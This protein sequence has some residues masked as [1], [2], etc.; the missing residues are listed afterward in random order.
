MPNWT[1]NY[2][3]VRGSKETLDQ[4]LND[5]VKVEG[6]PEGDYS[7][8]SWF[9]R[10]ETYDKY[11]TTNYTPDKLRPRL[12][13]PL[14]PWKKDSP[15]ITEELIAEYAQAMV[16]QRKR[17][18]AV[19][20]YDWNVK[21]YGCKWDENFFIQRVDD[22]T[23]KFNVTT[24]WVAPSVFFERISDRY[25]GLELEVDS[26]YEE[27]ENEWYTYSAGN[28]CQNDLDEFVSKLDEYI[29]NRIE[30]ADEIDGEP[31]T[32]EFK[33]KCQKAR[34][35]FITSGYWEHTSLEEEY[36]SFEGNLNW[37]IPDFVDSED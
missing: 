21:N 25:P 22:T 14:D 18:G 2:V 12:G 24:P 30:T 1:S 20:W 15:I 3:T 23:L 7:F 6:N 9:P 37:I 34:E 36:D 28:A 11:D 13:Q 10:P 19:G 16:E 4:F 8:G 27:G 17:Y 32:E 35:W 26:H 5:A 33:A 29:Q 31:A